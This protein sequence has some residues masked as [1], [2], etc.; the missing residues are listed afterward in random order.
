VRA[1]YFM[2]NRSR[3]QTR[4]SRILVIST[5]YASDCLKLG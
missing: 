2:K 4:Y 3:Y 5:V 1:A